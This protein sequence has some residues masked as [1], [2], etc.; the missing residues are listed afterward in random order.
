MG[1]GRLPRVI[2]GVLW[3][4]FVLM[5]A[6]QAQAA[7]IFSDGFESGDFTAWSQVQL[8][9]DGKALVQSQVVKTGAVAAELIETANTGSKAY[10]RKTFSTPSLDIT[11]SG[12]FNLQAEGASGGNVPIFR[13][14]DPAGTR[15]VS[16]YRQN[17]TTSNNIGVTAGTT[18]YTATSKLALNTWANVSMH[19]IINGAGSTVEIRVNGA[20]VLST[21]TASLGT[22]GVST[23]QI[24]NDTAAQAGN[25]VAD[26][27]NVVS[28][29][30][31]SSSPPSDTV[32]PVVSGT[33]QQGAT[34]TTGN[35][36]WTG[37]QPITFAYQ[38]QRCDTAGLNCVNIP[39]ATSANYVV[40]AADV[41]TTLRSVVTA[42]NS[43]G[44][45]SAAS[46]VTSTVQGAA[47][48]STNTAL[49][50]ITG[51]AQETQVLMATSGDWSGTQPITFT[52]QWK[53][54]DTA[55]ANCVNIGSPSSNTTYTLTSADVGSTI[56]VLV[57][58][59]NSAGMGTATSNPTAVV[60]AAATQPGLVALWHMNETSGTTMSDSVG[61]HTGTLHSVTLGVSPGFTGTAFG[62]NG[63]S[64]YV[65]VPSASDLNPGSANLTVTIHLKT[66]KV[67]ASPDWD[68]I[69]KGLYTTAGGEY[70]MEWQPTG[71]ASCGFKGSGGY[72]ELQ[73]GPAINDGQWH[74][75]Q[76]QKTSS[77]IKVIVDGAAFSKAANIGTTANTDAVPIG[78]RPGSE[79]F[80]GSLDEASIQVG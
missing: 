9:G 3:A 52:Y 53:R 37:T 8:A 35:G 38:W 15:L 23:V 56:R 80:N 7:T 21:T 58:A 27:I 12:N 49:P 44:T 19:T 79:F 41:G 78:A 30:T 5:A 57:T 20:L 60:Q 29:D 40:Q 42:T 65:S 22:S 14:L 76:C 67:P 77:A 61:S 39:S 63:T 31:A 26:D 18:R 73:A 34:L 1:V 6:G 46:Q 17:V 25:I 74:T 70:K 62:F 66:T 68:L 36:S 28:N 33:P 45:S 16:V 32:L 10:V 75:V 11:A 59:Q 64:S 55:G 72:A 47:V 13:F 4:M 54:C 50:T 71:Q 51:S 24:G 69:R 48:A 43:A 2:G